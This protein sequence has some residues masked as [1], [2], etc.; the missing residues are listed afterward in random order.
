MWQKAPETAPQHPSYYLHTIIHPFP[1]PN[2]INLPSTKGGKRA[3]AKGEGNLLSLTAC[4]N[5]YVRHLQG[6]NYYKATTSN[7]K[8]TSREKHT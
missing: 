1:C 2:P 6:S 4:G 8:L 5:E 7:W 3:K